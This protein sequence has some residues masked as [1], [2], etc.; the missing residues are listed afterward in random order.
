MS[1]PGGYSKTLNL[2]Q[3]QETILAYII[4]G[5]LIAY[6]LKINCPIVKSQRE[7]NVG[8]VLV[9]LVNKCMCVC[10]MLCC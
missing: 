8:L 7:Y 4:L 10:K 5:N 1:T 6:P 9:Y 3:V 2:A